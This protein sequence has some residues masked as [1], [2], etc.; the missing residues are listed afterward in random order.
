M[1]SYLLLGNPEIILIPEFLSWVGHKLYRLYKNDHSK[2]IVCFISS[3]IS[4]YL[5][6]IAELSANC[7]YSAVNVYMTVNQWDATF[8]FYFRH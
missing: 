4:M 2:H 7:M 8:Y 3:E 6:K 1:K 5:S